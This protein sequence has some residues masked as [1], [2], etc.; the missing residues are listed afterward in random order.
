MGWGIVRHGA[1]AVSA[2]VARSERSSDS[3]E[4]VPRSG[5][6]TRDVLQARAATAITGGAKVETRTVRGAQA[7]HDNQFAMRL[8]LAGRRADAGGQGVGLPADRLGGD[9]VGRARVGHPRARRR[10]RGLQPL[11]QREAGR[12]EVPV[13]LRAHRVLLRRLR[14]RAHRPGGGL[15]HLDGGRQVDSRARDRTPGHRHAAG[16]W[17]RR[18]STARSAGISSVRAGGPTPSSSRPTGST[19]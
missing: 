6:A 17:P 10:V 19:C 9:S 1:G 5:T 18:S 7:R 3:C 8:S 13:R 14:R 4:R 11:P 2:T 16:G 15:H 12:P